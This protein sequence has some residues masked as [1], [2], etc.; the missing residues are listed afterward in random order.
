M[1]TRDTR[2]YIDMLDDVAADLHAIKNTEEQLI[3][4]YG[5]FELEKQFR[6]KSIMLAKL[7]IEDIDDEASANQSEWIKRIK[8][9]N[10]EGVL[11]YAK[12]SLEYKPI[13]IQYGGLMDAITLCSISLKQRYDEL[14]QLME[15]YD[16]PTKKLSR[17]NKA[18]FADI[19]QYHDKKKLLARLHF[20]IDGKR[21][22][23]VGAVLMNACIINP[24]L[25][26]KPT[27]SE[28]EAEFELIGSW[29]AIT[30]YMNENSEKALQKAN[31]IIIFEQ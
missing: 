24:Y 6:E 9:Y 20:L 13:N 28:F 25:T 12:E 5:Y 3:Y 26:R 23:E 7:N 22:A 21:G 16:K 15:E 18:N 2:D 29:Q 27:R 14:V 30:N 17:K 10:V 8:E 19:I 31:K 11:S 4:K 1:K